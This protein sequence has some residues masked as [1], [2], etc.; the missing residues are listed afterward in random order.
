MCGRCGIN[1]CCARM[2]YLSIFRSGWCRPAAGSVSCV[3]MCLHT[4]AEE[5]S[6]RNSTAE[7]PPGDHWKWSVL[8]SICSLDE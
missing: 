7:L 1:V 2:K 4:T 3:Y 8:H 6:P 5:C